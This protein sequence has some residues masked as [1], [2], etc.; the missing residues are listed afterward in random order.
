M[1]ND[2]RPEYVLYMPPAEDMKPGILYISHEFSVA[3]HLCA[4]GC[5]KQVVTP[6]GK[7]EGWHLTENNGV[8]SLAP[9]IGNWQIECKSHYWIRDNKIVWA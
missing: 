9:S 2:I 8:V 4:S 5:G 6:I 3:I 7:P 1:S